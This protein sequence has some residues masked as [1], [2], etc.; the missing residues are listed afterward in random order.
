M[1]EQSVD[2]KKIRKFALQVLDDENGIKKEAFETLADILFETGNGDII[3]A[4][5][6]TD[7]KAYIGEDRAE[8][9]LKELQ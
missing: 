7:E 9:L 5:D 4:V 1:V 6:V 2:S 8:E 3:N